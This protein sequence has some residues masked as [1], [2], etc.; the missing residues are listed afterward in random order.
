MIIVFG[1]IN[2]DLVFRTAVL[3]REGETVLTDGFSTVPGGKGANQAVAA[4][5]A[6]RTGDVPVMMAGCVGE[7]AFAELALREMR[8]AGVDLSALT[9][10]RL[11]TGCAA[12]TV[13]AQG[14][15]QITVASGANL[16]ASQEAIRDEGLSARTVVVLQNEVADGANLALARRAVSRGARV[17]LNAAPARPLAAEDWSGLLKCLV[18][19]EAE[20]AAL[21]G[22]SD[23]RALNQLATSLHTTVVATLGSE[24]ALA[25][26]PDGASLRVEALPLETVV[27]TT[28]AG[29][30]FVGALASAFDE[31]QSLADALRF[32]S[33]AGGLA[34][35]KAGSQTSVPSRGDILA[36][37]S[38]VPPPRPIQGLSAGL[39]R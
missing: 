39:F 12:I 8:A 5:K 4:A 10:S 27:D 11:P 29:D 3:P 26:S 22:G 17:I 6:G 9:T 24:G 18:V 19:N 15:N 38:E 31:G 2:I 23:P 7:D 21:A 28:A 1:S 16:D 36:R 32:A 30:T 37:L 33:V 20:A 25:A 14:R 34:C 13:D 35:M